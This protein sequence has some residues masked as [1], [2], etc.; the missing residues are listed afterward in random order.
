MFVYQNNQRYTMVGND[1]F[2]ADHNYR[3]TSLYLMQS[4]YNACS[5][6]HHSLFRERFTGRDK[7]YIQ[8]RMYIWCNW[9]KVQLS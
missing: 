3:N 1:P 5:S 2:S 9:S 4:L 6:S 7:C 8:N